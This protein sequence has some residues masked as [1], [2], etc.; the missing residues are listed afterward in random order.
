MTQKELLDLS[1]RITSGNETWG[2]SLLAI[3][4]CLLEKQGLWLLTQ[5]DF[6]VLF[7]KCLGTF[8]KVTVINTT[9]ML[10]CKGRQGLLCLQTIQQNS[11]TL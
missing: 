5:V 6:I 10:H 2:H 1:E 9:I 7:I 8:E 3:F 11:Y 4:C